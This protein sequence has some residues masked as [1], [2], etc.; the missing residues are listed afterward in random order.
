MPYN[1]DANHTEIVNDFLRLGCAVAEI[2]RGNTHIAGWPDLVVGIPRHAEGDGVIIWVEVKAEGGD[3]G[4]AQTEFR[5]V[6]DLWPVE[7]ARNTE[8]VER[9]YSQYGT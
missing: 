6:W 4:V 2:A 7:V 3:L 9:I 8:D 5:Q 1:L